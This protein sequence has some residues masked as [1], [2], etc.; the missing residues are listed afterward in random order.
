MATAFNSI[1]APSRAIQ[2]PNIH[3]T[4]ATPANDNTPSR[5]IDDSRAK[6]LLASCVTN[7]PHGE[8]K[9]DQY[10]R[11]NDQWFAYTGYRAEA[12][13]AIRMAHGQRVLLAYHAIGDA[14]YPAFKAWCGE[15]DVTTAIDAALNT[16][17]EG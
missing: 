1:S 3:T 11:S 17:R 10:A 9:R 14:A 6:M 2:I 12:L 15:P 16:V 4:A 8:W 7:P 5:W 13:D